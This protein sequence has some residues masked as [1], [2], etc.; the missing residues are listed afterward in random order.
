MFKL[1]NHFL[2]R[3]VVI[4]LLLSLNTSKP[5][6]AKHAQ[7][8]VLNVSGQVVDIKGES[9]V[10]V[11]IF[12]K[13]TTTGTTT[14]VNGNFNIEVSQG[15]TL[16]FSFIGFNNQEI[17]ITD[18]K[19]LE[20]ILIENLEELDEVVVVGYGSQRKKDV[21]GAI[22]T[23]G[24]E[25][26]VQRP[27]TQV[28][29][30]LQGKAAGVQVLSSSGKPSQG[31]SIRIRGIN[32]IGAGSEPLYV[33]DGVPTADTRSINPADIEDISVLKDAASAA[34]Y[35]AQGGN[36]VVIISTKR[37]KSASPTL[38]LDTYFGFS[39]VWKQLDVLNGEQYR[40]LML[41]MGQDTYWDRY[42]HN[43][44]WQDEIFQ[45]G[46]SQNYQLSLSGANDK[47][48]YYISGGWT[49]QIGAVRSAEMKRANFKINLDQQVN[50]WVKAGTRISYTKYSDVD[51]NDFN[52]TNRSGVLVGA[53]ATPPVIGVYNRDGSFTSNPFQNWENPIASTDG[54]DRGY[55][56]QRFGGNA[57]LEFAPVKNLKYKINFGVFFKW[58]FY[59]FYKCSGQRC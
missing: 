54:T 21:T 11:S 48:N 14:D 58:Q 1:T 15:N 41:E 30:L 45:N 56:S 44:D 31:L 42:Y 51:V 33:V 25:D 12:V 6:L 10:G 8:S 29:S 43:T 3:I 5:M 13:G 24:E 27:N 26:M 38:S 18:Q 35:G 49:E 53:L 46:T 47:T 17:V 34:I 39:Q 59:Q 9:L 28:G 55:K 22:S 52:S 7:Q 16:V 4:G 50:D 32:S 36:G 57:Y 40:D 19:N 2:F 23:V 37:G 20:I